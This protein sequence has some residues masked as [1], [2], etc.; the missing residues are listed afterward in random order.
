MDTWGL[1]P[2]Y[3]N[4]NNLMVIVFEG[5]TWPPMLVSIDTTKG[6]VDIDQDQ[7]YQDYML[8]LEQN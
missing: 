4:I 3:N 1:E 7:W 8:S 2:K 5:A 6:T